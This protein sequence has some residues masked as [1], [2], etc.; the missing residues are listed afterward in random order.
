MDQDDEMHLD[1]RGPRDRPKWNI[2][3]GDYAAKN[4]ENATKFCKIFIDV[5]N[6]N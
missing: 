4:I 2:A 1:E 5:Q 3:K 6:F